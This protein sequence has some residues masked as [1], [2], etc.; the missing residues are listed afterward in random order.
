MTE[1]SH[2]RVSRC[3]LPDNDD[4]ED[5][6]HLA[7]MA[8]DQKAGQWNIFVCDAETIQDGWEMAIEEWN[9]MGMHTDNTRCVFLGYAV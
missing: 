9:C 4:T 6:L 3:F 1:S 5:L 8:R 2:C 7:Y